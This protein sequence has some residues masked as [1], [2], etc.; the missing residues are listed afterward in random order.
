MCGGCSAAVKGMLLKQPGVQ[1]AAV[2]LLTET[3]AITI[4]AGEAA[5]VTAAA[6]FLSKKVRHQ[7]QMC[8]ASAGDRVSIWHD[9]SEMETA[10]F[11]SN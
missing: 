5:Q 1:A 10:S 2:N 7:Q 9:M 6:E 4:R 11:S 3:A 8:L